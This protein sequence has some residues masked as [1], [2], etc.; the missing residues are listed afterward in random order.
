M[1]GITP[2]VAGRGGCGEAG[3]EKSRDADCG[4]CR[5]VS[6][7]DAAGPGPALVLRR[8][9]EHPSEGRSCKHTPGRDGDATKRPVLEVTTLEPAELASNL[10]RLASNHRWTWVASARRLLDR[11]PTS[12]HGVHPVTA[13][14][15]LTGTDLELLLADAGWLADLLVEADSLGRLLQEPIDPEVVYFSPEFAISEL[16][17]QYSGGLGVLAGDHL[18]AAHPCPR[19]RSGEHRRHRST[20]PVRRPVRRLRRTYQLHGRGRRL[21]ESTRLIRRG[22][23][24]VHAASSEHSLPGPLSELADA[25]LE[26]PRVFTQGSPLLRFRSRPWGGLSGA[27]TML[28]D[29]GE[30]PEQQTPFRDSGLERRLDRRISNMIEQADAP[31]EV[32]HRFDL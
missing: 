17:P 26:D 4:L 19:V 5:A 29:L 27:T 15:R 20:D 10:T 7:P 8:K 6:S 14:S 25:T 11:I 23:L 9:P 13:V 18:K 12:Q 32:Y 24:S 22:A 3:G 2:R 16:I 21:H 28:F 30:D 1:G 31:A